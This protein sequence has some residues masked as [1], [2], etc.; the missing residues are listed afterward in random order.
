MI[1]KKF[2]ILLAALLAVCTTGVALADNDR[3]ISVGELPASSQQFINTYFKELAVSYAKVDEE[4]FDKEYK[5]LFVNGSKVEFIR[6]GDWKEVDCR[7]GEVPAGIVPQPIL[8]YVNTRFTGRTVVRI[9][10]ERKGYDVGLDNGLD[11]K[12][13]RSFRLVDIDD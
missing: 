6:N 3:M 11:L 2:T 10:R 1:M 13:D 12:F 4:W 5:V 9:E 7:Y 8:D